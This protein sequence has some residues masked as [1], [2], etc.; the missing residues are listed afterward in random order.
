MH[1]LL[2]E[3]GI[4]IIAATL[5]GILMHRIRQP[6]ILGYLLAGAFIG[7][8]MGLRLVSTPENIEIISE[9]G[10]ILLLFIIGL[11][12]DL[13][14][15][16]QSGKQLM[17]SGIGQFAVCVVV[18][19][20]FFPIVGY[21]V[22]GG[23]ISGLYLALACALSST[24]IVVKLL[25]DKFELDTIAGRLT[26]GILVIQ[27]VWAILILAFQPNFASPN[28]TLLVVAVLKAAA[29]VIF[30]FTFSKYV[31]RY[32]FSWIA[33]TP[34]MVVA[35][36]IGWCAVVAGAA[37]FIGLSKEMGALIAGVAISTL[38]YSIH[39]TAKTLPLRDFFL[40]LFFISLGMKMTMPTAG[41][42]AAAGVVVAFVIVSRFISVYPLLKLAGAGRRT[43]FITSLNIAQISEFSLVIASLGIG[44]GHIGKDVMSVILYA[45]AVTSVLSSYS[46][47]YNH[48]LYLLFEK[49]MALVGRHRN[50]AGF[51]AADHGEAP[52]VVILGFHRGA[53]SLVETLRDRAPAMLGRI[54]VVDFNLETLRE[55]KSMGVHGMFGDIASLD[56]LEHAH[57]REAQVILSTIPDMLLKGIKNIDLVEMCR[58][59]APEAAIVA[60]ADSTE[61]AEKIRQAGAD[62]VLMPYAMMGEALADLLERELAGRSA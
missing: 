40:T 52:A 4:S 31:L 2:A 14:K 36:S 3:I 19:L 15:I 9:I 32:V 61:Q 43:A 20:L 27:D 5:M 34:E 44:Y 8:E 24:A 13:K 50:V 22:R 29:L 23:N 49:A 38:P 17:V 57:I 35:V 62:T 56:T 45:M 48:E 55:L 10:L 30:G 6:I 46:I 12:M 18:G 7:P 47:A 21:A 16:A 53:R 42:L 39:V 1:G 26:L 51:E 11:E 33:K 28:I 58:A 41:L 60:T 59:A 37:G 54:M 25:Y